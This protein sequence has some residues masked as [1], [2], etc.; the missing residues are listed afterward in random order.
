MFR[1]RFW[2]AAAAWVLVAG[3]LAPETP[4]QALDAPTPSGLSYPSF[5]PANGGAFMVHATKAD[6][7]VVDADGDG[8]VDPGDQ[9]HYTIVATNDSVTSP[10]NNLQFIDYYDPYTT[11]VDGTETTTL[12]TIAGDP[13]KPNPWIAGD[14][15]ILAAGASATISFDVV[16]DNNLPLDK[17]YIANQAV[18]TAEEII[19]T[20]T[21]DPDTLRAGDATLTPVDLPVITAAKT[22]QLVG[23]LDGDGQ[24]GPGDTIEYTI[25]ITNS[26]D[27]PTTGA[28]FRD[29]PD[30][31]S[32]LVSGSVTTTLGTVG[33]G[34][35]TG[36]SEV[37][38]E[39]GQIDVNAAVTITF[40]VTVNAPLAQDVYEVCN[41][42]VGAGA[43]FD[44]VPTDDPALADPDDPTCVYLDNYAQYTATKTDE[45]VDDLNGNGQADPGDTIQYTVQLTNTG[46]QNAS[47]F[48]FTDYPSGLTTLAA[49][50]VQI[51]G[52]GSYFVTSGNNPGDT[53]VYG[54]GGPVNVGSS[55]TIVFQVVV[56]QKLPAGLVEILNQ[57]W[58]YG[59]GS[60]VTDDPDTSPSLDPTITW[61]N[62]LRLTATKTDRLLT[63]PTCDGLAEPGEV[64]EYTVRI[65]NNE[66]HP[67]TVSYHESAPIGT[68]FLPTSISPSQG[69]INTAV[70]S[71]FDVWLG[72]IPGNGGTATIVFQAQIDDP[73]LE[74]LVRISN[75]G[76]FYGD[77]FLETP[78][79]DPDTPT[80]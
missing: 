75:Q 47:T 60:T 1:S 66:D 71:F 5:A 6:E 25:V 32:A 41:Q 31:N 76:S 24:A 78:T 40:R 70:D 36:D 29:T 72:V 55:V 13:G 57:G 42:G 43:N 19:P 35:N 52:G 9:I 65:T 44:D 30:P 33:Q 2:M 50:T 68:R 61:A 26:G 20:P 69:V 39:I 11:A 22:A 3:A 45:L 28:V 4:A 62:G 77:E 23:D 14:M 7:L 63:D 59:D 49:G 58:F 56:N 18:F 21:D 38:V 46:H 48:D 10:L 34:N 16:A 51:L 15:G 67:T 79:D 74:N 8:F 73:L 27:R 17:R 54:G 53:Y 12:G 64:I 80:M 37:R